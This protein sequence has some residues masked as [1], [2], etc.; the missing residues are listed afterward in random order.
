MRPSRAIVIAAFLAGA[1]ASVSAQAPKLDDVVRRMGSYIETYEGRLALVVAEENYLQAFDY[2]EFTG[3]SVEVSRN[4]DRLPVGGARRYLRSDYALTRA[5]DKDAWVGY[6][7]TFEV[8]GRAIRDREARLERLLTA[9][10]A[11]SASRL[12]D[13]SSRFNLANSIVTRNINVPTLVLEML[14]PRNQSRF[15]F[16]KGGDETIGGVRTWRVEFK[17]KERP[18]FIRDSNRRD[19]PSLGSVWV[20]PMTGEVWRTML[21]WDSDPRGTITVTYGHVANIEP[22][23]PLTMSERYSP[24]RSQL[25]GDATYS[26][27]R[28]FQTGARLVNP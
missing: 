20:N 2:V 18:T 26:N 10:N 14:H 1:I 17:E 15:S 13:E 6:R 12:A 4:S 24:G 27:Y 8:D 5:P 28:Q 21:R 7:D 23:V 19:R 11:A 25:T 9:G 3:P 22:L 16:S